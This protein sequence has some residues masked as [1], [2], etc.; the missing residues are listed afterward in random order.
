MPS[1]PKLNR[2]VQIAYAVRDV[3]QAA[4][5]FAAATGAGPFFV[6]KHIPLISARI[7][8]E[9]SAFDHSSAYGQ[10][11]EVMV[12]LVEEHTPAIVTPPNSHHKAFIVPNLKE[13]VT[14]CVQQG[15]PEAL[16]AELGGGTAFA[17]CDARHQLG[18]LIEMYEPTDGLLAFYDFVKSAA[19]G[20]DGRDP[21]RLLG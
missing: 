16:W 14:W 1:R 15:W 19:Q 6:R 8:G 13:A 5:R 2:V 12:E 9:A 10:W 21:V 20:W 17:F 4:Q 3:E 11:G 7:F 18:H